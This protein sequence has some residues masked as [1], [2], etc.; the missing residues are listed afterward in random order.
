MKETQL[1]VS[2]AIFLVVGVLHLLRF[3][4]HWEVTIAGHPVAVWVSAPVGLAALV[5]AAWILKPFC[6]K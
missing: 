3:L 4:A 6:C 2:G 1:K 5:L